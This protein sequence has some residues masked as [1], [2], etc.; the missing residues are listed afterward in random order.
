MANIWR[1]YRQDWYNL[2]KAPVALLLVC[3]LVVLPSVYDWVNV[4]AVWD[5]YSNTS[6]IRIAVASLD[7]GAV[8]EGR[9]FNIGEQVME[10]L[11]GNKTLGWTFT[12]EKAAENGVRRGDYYASI[13]I[14]ADFSRK[15]AGI[16][17]GRLE[18]PELDYTVNEK[19]NAVA[20][21]ITAKG[22]STISA[23]IS[24][25]FT[26]E[27]SRTVLTALR[28]ADREF[29]AELPLI[30][31]VEQGLFTL[32][33]H[34]PELESAGRLVM[35]LQRRWPEIAGDAQAVAALTDRLPELERA[36]QAAQALDAGW[37][38]LSAAAEHLRG[39]Q[40]KLPALQQAA[41][42]TAAF[43]TQFGRVDEL[44]A[45]ASA[46]LAEAEAAVASAADK[47]PDAAQ[48]SAAGELERQLQ[49]YLAQ[50]GDAF[51][52]VP[53]VLQQNLRLL[54]QT[55]HAAAL[56]AGRLEGGAEPAA[57]E[58][59]SASASLAAGSAALGDAA[60]LLA[61][62]N[63]LAP[64]SVTGAELQGLGAA[65]Q[66]Y[67]AGAEQAGRLAAGL[68]Q[69]GA[70]A[71]AQLARF[72]ETAQQGLAAL[73]RFAAGYSGRTQPELRRSLSRLTASA[74]DSSGA[75]QDVPQ[76]LAALA[77][78]LAEA[79][80]AIAFGQSGLA[81]LQ[82]RLPGVRSG[83]QDAA[84]GIT[85]RLAA[86]TG[87]VTD[88]LP[89]IE[90]G[91]PAAGE[92]VHRA[93]VFA[94]EDLPAV[95]QR[96]RTAAQLVETG[97]PQAGKGVTRAAGIVRGDLP[98]LEAAVHKAAAT[99][100]SVKKEV[101]LD[102]LAQLLGGD[103]KTTSD[104]LANPVE[105]KERA[106]YPIPNYGSAMT[107][108]YV[109]LSLWVGGTLLVSL[110]RTTADAGGTRRQLYFGRL[111]TFLTIGVLQALVASLGNLLI[112]GGYAADQAWFVLSA[113]LISL[114]F[115]TIIYSLV[116][117]FGNMGKGIAIIF[118]VLQFSS[119]GGTFPV[120]TTGRFF[121]TLHPFM[122]FTYAISLMRETVGGI[123]PEV[124]V[125][126]ALLLILFGL[127]ALLLALTLQKPLEPYIRRAAERAE[128]SG[129]IS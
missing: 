11:H 72:S 109:V 83:L 103:I 62:V 126:D 28:E 40:D 77:S 5:P 13:V 31:R 123:L 37:P 120:S 42:L 127:L 33:E 58:L 101:N 12:D 107:P 129:L 3:A 2:F 57:P 86:L 71:A 47:L 97:L 110:L 41:E 52:A 8:I 4:A 73:E 128:K 95:E 121:Q 115:V 81:A 63:A 27:I 67:G 69:G 61:A 125:R 112:L 85:D 64:G 60:A 48:F 15:L 25:G 59:R 89:R 99:V 91:L 44:L 98:A 76:Q 90:S 119:S 88:V 24:E 10:S 68:E 22:A 104:F 1:I 7:E 55:G 124:A 78:L 96:L 56:L 39:L 35:E 19:I 49:A 94:R 23:Q 87:L 92:A 102:E 65:Q 53:E 30:R 51:A 100:R 17:E 54:Q 38:Q 84:G 93:A 6:G 18:R 111:L 45:S 106:L 36:G 46:R 20:P 21:K 114:V 80:E 29:Q 108:F 74:A 105:L 26:E 122:P 118:M 16:L 34:L 75:L 32:E 70:P 14:P 117:V 116:A 50:H 43:N 79:K 82:Q 113:L 9:K 66:R